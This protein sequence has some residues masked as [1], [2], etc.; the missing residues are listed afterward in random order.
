MLCTGF[1]YAQ[2]IDSAEY[3]FD[4]D[5]GVGNGNSLS[6][7]PNTGEVSQTYMIDISTLSNGFH[8]L[9]IRTFNDDNN[10][11]LYD[12]SNFYIAE[13]NSGQ[14]VIAAEYFYDMDD[15]V[16]TGEPLVIDTQNPNVTQSLMIPT[17]GLD[18]G[19]HDLYIRTQIADGT[20]S[21]YDRQV[22][23]ISEFS[24]MTSNVINA[25]YYIDT[26]PGVGAGEPVNITSS[27]QVITFDTD[28]LSEGDH[29]F[30]VRVQNEDGVWSFYSCEIFTI[31]SSLSIEDSL[32]KSTTIFPNPFVDN[33][34][35]S[36]IYSNEFKIILVFDLTGKVV[37]ES[38]NNL[39][40]ISLGHLN[41]G[42]YILKLITNKSEANFKIVKR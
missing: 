24:N 15:G 29:L 18:E 3:F 13:L 20:W 41:Q 10:W 6:V 33:V 7:D 12:R 42:T 36:T 40:K 16:G 19:F 30:C 37:F 23:Y 38:A 5:P 27:P 21:L 39:N 31:D 28:G 17:T 32:Y 22:I 8:D 14:N 34:E 4:T 25:E 1:C 9:Y 26:D 11:S 2:S 35:I